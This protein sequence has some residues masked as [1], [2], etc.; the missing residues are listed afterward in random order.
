MAS[1]ARTAGDRTYHVLGV[2]LRTGSLYPGNEN[3]ARAYRDAGLME[4]LRTAG[5]DAVDDGDVDIAKS[6]MPAAYFPHADGL[7]LVEAGALLRPLLAD[8]RIRIVEVAEYASLAD[9]DR[10]AV[11]RLIDVLAGSLT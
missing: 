1:N 6:D 8:A 9:P 3:D 4:R 2:P 10:R 11:G 7:T 5:L